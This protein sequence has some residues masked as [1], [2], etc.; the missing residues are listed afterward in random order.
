MGSFAGRLSVLAFVILFVAAATV[1]SADGTADDVVLLTNGGIVKG[2]II[3]REEGK[4]L[5]VRTLDGKEVN[6]PFDKISQ[7]TTSDA[8]VEQLHQLIIDSVQQRRGVP[9]T[10][11][12]TNI[13]ARLTMRTGKDVTAFGVSGVVELL[14]NKNFSIGP[15]AGWDEHKYG[16]LLP[17]FSEI[18]YYLP[19]ENIQPFLY[20]RAGFSIGW[21]K[22][23]V[24]S[25]FGGARW[26]VGAGVQKQ[27]SSTMLLTAQL[28]YE[29]QDLTKYNPKLS[30]YPDWISA[31]IG[32]K[33]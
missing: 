30:S 32:L 13:H 28:G 2:R 29:K 16:S 9:L 4:K 15:G 21:M 6:I 17:I 7:I 11:I 18:C 3:K 14:T 8:N 1:Y 26:G 24:G 25:D 27:I 10:V 22:G 31:T 33:L 20:G 23:L 5:T 12:A 19:V